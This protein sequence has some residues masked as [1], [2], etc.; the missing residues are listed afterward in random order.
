LGNVSLGLLSLW[1]EVSIKYYLK[2][3]KEETPLEILWAPWRLSYVKEAGKGRDCFICEAISAPRERDEENL[4]LYR[5]KRAVVILNKYPYN[6]AH[7]LV[8]PVR[9]TGDFLSLLPE[10]LAEIDSLLKRSMAAISRVYSPDGYNVGLN[11][12]KV[13]GGSVNTHIHYHVVPRWLG[14]T[15][16]MPVVGG[17]KVIPQSL[18]ETYRLLKEAWE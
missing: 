6:T 3:S 15:N 11:L 7:L 18:S 16:F 17:V 12:G 1:L 14:D 2:L 13:S 4:L 5:G 8:C 9:H 10:E